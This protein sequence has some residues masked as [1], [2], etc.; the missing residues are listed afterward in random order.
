MGEPLRALIIEDQENDALLIERELR[1]AGFDLTIERV[2]TSDA[3]AAALDDSR[4]DIVI[5]DYSLPAF[6][7]PAAL[8]VLT[9][10]GLDLP[11]LIVSGTVGEDVA[12]A[13]MRLGAHD[14]IMKNNLTRLAPAVSREV[15]EARG[16]HARRQAEEA[17]RRTEEQFRQ[18]QKMEAM[19]RLAGGIAHDFNNLLTAILGYGDLIT[20][21]LSPADPLRADMEEILK[22]ADRGAALTR[23]LL[24]FSRQQ[25]LEPQILDLNSIVEGV[26]QL[27]RRLLG[28]DIEIV[29]ECD[30]AL[31]L[32][33]ADAGQLEQ[34]IMNLAVNARDAME[35][36][37]RLTIET[38]NVLLQA[39]DPTLS[40]AV[41]PGPYVRLAVSD[42]G[43]G[44]DGDTLPRIFEPFFTTKER[45]KGTGL[46]LSTV[47]GIV[48]QSS[49]AIGVDSAPHQGTTFRIYLPHSQ[50]AVSDKDIA[51]TATAARGSETV[52]LVEDEDAVREL[53]RKSLERHGFRVLAAESSSAAL[54]LVDTAGPIDLMVTDV[55]M[56]EL[57]GPA[58]AERMKRL[59]PG[60]KVLY[61][62]GYTDDEALW[63]FDATVPFLQKPF[64][65]ESLARKVRETLDTRAPGS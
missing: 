33:Q 8:R 23:Q 26:A 12:V 60:M 46:G 64:T 25:L 57:G 47:Y 45:G 24:A 1:R 44:I 36:G 42:T 9:A 37:G 4:W 55:L 39:D 11:F 19:G 49:G 29:V 34:V 3:L 38:S 22:A 65:P 32:I 18:A 14:Y 27:I 54:A 58:L 35:R 16:R 51:R 10:R 28:P 31:G 20:D 17:L 52:L 40:P 59:R 13:A 61:I 56:P 43:F 30:P 7:A 15:R 63:Q 41:A 2:E 50:E 6:D 21:Q 48:T 5:S 53:I 62:S